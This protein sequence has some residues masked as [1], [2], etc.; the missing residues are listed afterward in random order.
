MPWQNKFFLLNSYIYIYIYI[1]DET[2]PDFQS[3]RIRIRIRI[4]TL[5][6]SGYGSVSGSWIRD[7]RI[8]IRVIKIQSFFR[9]YCLSINLHT[10]QFRNHFSGLDVENNMFYLSWKI[11]TW[12]MPLGSFLLWWK[13]WYDTVWSKSNELAKKIYLYPRAG[14]CI[15]VYLVLTWKK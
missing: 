11:S 15:L 2:D 6:S 3:I 8:R 1:R 5:F 7:P 12:K 13:P 14:Q 4:L 9:G 10:C